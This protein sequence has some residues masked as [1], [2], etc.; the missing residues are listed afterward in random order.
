MRVHKLTFAALAVA[1]SLPLTACDNG[2]VTGKAGPSPASSA[3]A[4]GHGSGPGGSKQGGTKDSAEKKSGGQSTTAESADGLQPGDALTSHNFRLQM[5]GA[6]VEYLQEVSGLEDDKVTL[7]RGATHSAAV[8][9][10]IDDA[11]AGREGRLKDVTVEALDY[12]NNAVKQYQ[13]RGAFVERVTY[14]NPPG[15]DA[16]TVR[17]FT[18]V[19]N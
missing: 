8:D 10:W 15:T 1:V 4:S 3:S 11:I 12:Q 14:S 2:D 7:V 19:I 9:R 6:P 17:F 13:L 16:L 18:L 5:D